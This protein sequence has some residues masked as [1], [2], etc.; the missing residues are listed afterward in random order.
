METLARH[1][2]GAKVNPTI[3]SNENGASATLE[4]LKFCIIDTKKRNTEDLA[5]DSPMQL[6]LP[7]QSKFIFI[8][9]Y[10]FVHYT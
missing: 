3:G 4:N 8:N 9:Q 2:C 1:G 10:I 7:I 6:L 5:K